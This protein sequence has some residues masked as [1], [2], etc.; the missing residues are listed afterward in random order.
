MLLLLLLVFH[1]C[2][3]EGNCIDQD[4][5]SKAQQQST[6]GNTAACQTANN[7]CLC[8]LKRR[9]VLDVVSLICCIRTRGCVYFS[10]ST[11]PALYSNFFQVFSLGDE[12][13]QIAAI[14]C[15]RKCIYHSD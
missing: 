8:A 13:L 14:T 10:H 5:I 3:L 1:C 15:P 12:A 9:E 4:A 11:L 2:C 7:R 6:P